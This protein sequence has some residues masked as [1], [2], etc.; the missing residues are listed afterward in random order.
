MSIAD[1][2]TELN[3]HLLAKGWQLVEARPEP[4]PIGWA[5]IRQTLRGF[6]GQSQITID[7]PENSYRCVPA[8]G[9]AGHELQYPPFVMG[10]EGG[11]TRHYW[12]S[13]VQVS[14]TGVRALTEEDPQK[15][16]GHVTARVLLPY[17]SLISAIPTL[18]K[19][20]KKA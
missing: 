10:S 7:Y 8:N 20:V 19:P 18:N 16:G 15:Y 17:D 4:K 5:A 11:M 14:E 9:A 12:L 3:G 6:F 13:V 2:V 1:K